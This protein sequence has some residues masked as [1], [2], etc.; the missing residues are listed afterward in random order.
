MGNDFT[1][2]ISSDAYEEIVNN[3][4][5]DSTTWG[6]LCSIN[7]IL[8][9]YGKNIE[10]S[11]KEK[12][13]I[14][15]HQIEGYKIYTYHIL[16]SGIRYGSYI[17]ETPNKNKLVIYNYEDD[18]LNG[19]KSTYIDNYLVKSQ[20]FQDDLLNGLSIQ[21]YKNGN[22]QQEINY[23]NNFVDG[24]A[25]YWYK[26]GVKHMIIPYKDGYKDGLSIQW[27]EN[28]THPGH[29]IYSRDAIVHTTSLCK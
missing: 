13:K 5:I 11:M 14:Q 2:T 20:E 12:Y 21:W 10:N 19:S 15:K 23:K 26:N 4:N 25:T 6:T 1:L 27:D 3:L 8:S 24:L 9:Q 16:P 28:G 17:I 29:V 18:K 22:K 7:K